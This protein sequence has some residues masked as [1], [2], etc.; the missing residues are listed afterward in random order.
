MA[1]ARH[2]KEDEEATLLMSF[3][4]LSCGARGQF[5]PLLAQVSIT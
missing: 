2:T 4:V 1:H 5:T 3:R